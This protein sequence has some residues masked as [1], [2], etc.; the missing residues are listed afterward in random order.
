MQD[1]IMVQIQDYDESGLLVVTWE[2]LADEFLAA[3]GNYPPLVDAVA[4][5]RNGLERVSVNLG[6]GGEVS[7]VLVR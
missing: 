4:E 6:A 5:L 3:N 2:G 7:L 1:D